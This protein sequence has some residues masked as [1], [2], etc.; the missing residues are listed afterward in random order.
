MYEHEKETE[1]L[2]HT[3]VGVESDLELLVNTLYRKILS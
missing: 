3:H 2:I 1:T